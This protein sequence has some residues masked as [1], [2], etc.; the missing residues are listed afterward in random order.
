MLSKASYTQ[1]GSKL[2]VV[3]SV[4]LSVLSFLCAALLCLILWFLISESWTLIAS[5]QWQR[6]FLDEGWYPLEGLYAMTPMIVASL[7][8]TLGA[9]LI[10][11]PIGLACAIYLEFYAR[12]LPK[13]VFRSLL[14]LLAG[15]PSVVFGLW[16]LTELVP[17]IAAIKAPGTSVLAGAIVLSLMILPTVALTSAAALSGVN[18]NTLAG[19]H[20][21]G[22]TQ[23]TMI[24]AVAIPSARSG[25]ISGV[26]LSTARAIGETMVVLMVAGNVVQMPDSLFA[27]VRALTSNIALEM[28]YA[29]GDHRA[30][31]YAS[32]LLLTLIVWLLAYL[33]SYLNEKSRVFARV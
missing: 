19:A 18:R 20:A 29:L 15:I 21:L 27:P 26:L 10:A 16:G 17:L 14:N 3:V 33:A 7:A 11:L 4:V 8:L 30:S 24:I 12:G 2:D 6:F 32:G 1:L 31:L 5:G 9:V 13:K 25:I 22:F 23:K 28:A